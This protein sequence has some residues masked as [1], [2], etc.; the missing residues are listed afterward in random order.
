MDP[1]SQALIEAILAQDAADEEMETG[2]VQAEEEYLVEHDPVA[3]EPKPSRSGRGKPRGRGKRN[4]HT[5]SSKVTSHGQRW[6][7]EEDE[8]LARGIKMFGHGNWSEIA[9]FM[10]TRTTRQVKNHAR[11]LEAYDKLSPSP[12]EGPHGRAMR[13]EGPLEAESQP[14]AKKVQKGYAMK[15]DRVEDRE[16]SDIDVDI[17][18]GLDDDGMSHQGNS[19]MVNIDHDITPST[20]DI[21][22]SS[23]HDPLRSSFL[24]NE[25]GEEE[26]EEEEEG[27]GSK[28]EAEKPHVKDPNSI[29]LLPRHSTLPK[30][31]NGDDVSDMPPPRLHRPPSREDLST[32]VNR[33][34]LI[35]EVV[36]DVPVRPISLDSSAITDQEQVDNP[37]WFVG[38]PKRTPERYMEIRNGI[39]AAWAFY[40][41]AYMSKTRA[42]KGMRGDVNIVGEIFDYLERIG[43]INTG[44]EA[45]GRRRAP[46]QRS[47]LPWDWQRS[48]NDR[49]GAREGSE[50]R[51]DENVMGRAMQGH[52]LGPRKRRVRDSE[53]EWVTQRELEGRVIRHE[54]PSE[55]AMRKEAEK[56]DF[57]LITPKPYDSP[58]HNTPFRIRCSP[59]VAATIDVHAHLVS[60][61]IIGLLSGG[62][63][64]STGT[65]HIRGLFP[66]QGLNT[67]GIQ[68]EMDPGSEME[69][70]DVFA[71]TKQIAVGWYHSHPMFRPDPSV[72]DVQTQA[73]YQSLFQS[74]QGGPCPF[75]G[76]IL[77][78]YDLDDPEVQ[79]SELSF[80]M[81]QP[82]AK[83]DGKQEHVPYALEVAYSLT[84][85]ETEDIS[86]L[87]HSFGV[88]VHKL[89]LQYVQDDNLLDPRGAYRARKPQTRWE[90]LI[91][92]V[93]SILAPVLQDGPETFIDQVD[94]ILSDALALLSPSSNSPTPPTPPVGSAEVQ[95]ESEASGSTNSTSSVI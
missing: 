39:L 54:D 7:P 40:Q 12:M 19:L 22:S 79:P 47:H 38:R 61:E 9:D 91:I 59:F 93:K 75:V 57:D 48:E 2:R 63:D 68:V 58:D 77:Q 18:E 49:R 55:V 70:R 86:E 3:R 20:E 23:V 16:P 71:H 82:P 44:K 27:M 65:L 29:A 1:E 81:A 56:R 15:A 90:H 46:P 60:N 32:G 13:E 36:L 30:Y 67:S 17:D 4:L 92:S 25:S 74:D 8:K 53:G 51:E 41:P 34:G 31:H 6:L 85:G 45:E 42:R 33:F 84:E 37:E 35:P 87:I 73:N 24:V 69:A 94:Q 14:E 95:A 64:E 76:A 26:E 88:Q 72:R 52:E 28:D 83:D 62:L 89:A 11:H 78:P 66:C 80:F 43:A 10:G 21:V 5:D 50:E